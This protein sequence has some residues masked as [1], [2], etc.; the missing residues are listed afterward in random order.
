MDA[1]S[2]RMDEV[3]NTHSL[4]CGLAIYVQDSGEAKNELRPFL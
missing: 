4:I 1:I 3:A 2:S